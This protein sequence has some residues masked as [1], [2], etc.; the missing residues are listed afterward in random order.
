MSRPSTRPTVGCAGF[1][2]NVG[3]PVFGRFLRDYIELDVLKRG[4][5]AFTNV[6]DQAR[7][8]VRLAGLDSGGLRC[9]SRSPPIPPDE[10]GLKELGQVYRSFAAKKK[11]G[12]KNLKELNIKGQQCPIAVE[13]INSGKLVVQWGAPLSPEGEGCQRDPRLYRVGSRARGQCPLAGRHDDQED[14]PGRVQVGRQ[15]QQPMRRRAL[16]DPI[17]E[18]LSTVV[19]DGF[20]R[21]F[22]QSGQ[23][24]GFLGGVG[25]LAIDVA[26]ALGIVAPEVLRGRLP[27]E[28]AIDARGIDIESAGDVLLQPLCPVSHGSPDASKDLLYGT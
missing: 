27:A 17:A 26:V 18:P 2:R 14:D 23:S 12:P 7:D 4:R 9:N 21:A 3:I 25:G 11:R 28:V 10:R 6:V 16:S 5:D 8:A 15:G 13:M 1:P 20:N 22:L 19:A 24:G